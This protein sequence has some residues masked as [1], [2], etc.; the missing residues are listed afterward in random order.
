MAFSHP[1]DTSRLL[2]NTQFSTRVPRTRLSF[3]TSDGSYSALPSLWGRQCPRCRQH[4]SDP[5]SDTTSR[6]QVVATARTV[7]LCLQKLL[8]AA[9]CPLKP[10]LGPLVWALG[11]MGTQ[12]QSLAA[13]LQHLLTVT[14]AFQGI[15]ATTPLNLKGFDT[16]GCLS[17]LPP[18]LT[19]HPLGH[20]PSS[21]AG[22]NLQAGC[23]P[24]K[25]TQ[26]WGLAPQKHPCNR[27]VPCPLLAPGAMEQPPLLLL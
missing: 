25:R 3:G 9:L 20:G 2:L 5:A 22:I 24:Q 18:I 17:C 11:R 23:W 19:C 6:C 13:I 4:W 15:S 8:V 7:L 27:Q 12:G 14:H 21:Q 26:K 10:P 16:S 1:P